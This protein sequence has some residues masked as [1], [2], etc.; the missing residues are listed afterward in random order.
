MT[1]EIKTIDCPNIRFSMRLVEDVFNEFVAPDYSEQG[2]K[3]FKET[4]IYNQSYLAKFADGREKMYGAYDGD[5]LVGC[6]SISLHNTISCIFVKKEYQRKG[7]AL[8]LLNT[9]IEKLKNRGVTVIKL[10]ASPYA[11]PF[12]R[13]MGFTSIGDEGNYNGIR[14]TPMMLTIN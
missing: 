6:L 2:V 14:Y 3:T 1:L 13:A 10:N 11:I 4:F 12:Y 8:K 5:T 9:V 7:I